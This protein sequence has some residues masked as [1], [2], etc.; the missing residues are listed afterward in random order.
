M[1]LYGELGLEEAMGLSLKQ[2]RIN[3]WQKAFTPIS[4]L[5][6]KTGFL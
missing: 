4:T 3:W 1:A 5:W 2:T 6:D